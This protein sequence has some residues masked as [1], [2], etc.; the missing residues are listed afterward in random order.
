MRRGR[1]GGAGGR[2]GASG[3]RST[4][5]CGFSARF[6]RASSLSLER[7][8]TFKSYQTQC[9]RAGPAVQPRRARGTPYTDPGLFPVG[10][11][12][13]APVPPAGWE[14][15]GCSLP[16]R[17]VS[18]ALVFIRPLQEPEEVGAAEMSLPGFHSQ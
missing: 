5:G 10:L 6:S 9:T 7:P 4:G 17:F 2:R 3:A 12:A 1:G 8:E 16:A 15:R 14:G 18:S 13:A 11:F